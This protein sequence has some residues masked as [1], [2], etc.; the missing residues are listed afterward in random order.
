MLKDNTMNSSLSHNIRFTYKIAVFVQ[1]ILFVIN[2]IH[3]YYVLM[4]LLLCAGSVNTE[5]IACIHFKELG[6]F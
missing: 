2:I 5:R 4:F 1:L 6:A 3:I